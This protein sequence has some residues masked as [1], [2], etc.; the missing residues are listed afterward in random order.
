MKVPR[1]PEQ[2]G[3]AVRAAKNRIFFGPAQDLARRE[4]FHPGLGNDASI[5]SIFNHPRTKDEAEAYLAAYKV[6]E[7]R[8]NQ[9][10]G[11]YQSVD[12]LI[13]G[14][15]ERYGRAVHNA[16]ATVDRYQFLYDDKVNQ[17][18]RIR[19]GEFPDWMTEPT[20]KML[21]E[22]EE[23]GK[24]LSEAKG[25]LEHIEQD[26]AKERDERL[27]YLESLKS[28]EEVKEQESRVSQIL[29]AVKNYKG[30]LTKRLKVPKIRFLRQE[31]GITD[32]TVRERNVA[33]KKL[34]IT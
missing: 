12:Y 5:R 29:N 27:V 24:D 9:L 30:P 28:E 34:N 32:M 4:G 23:A 10:Y 26:A 11:D 13:K 33:V 2:L 31:S 3:L 19:A 7:D 21:T 8:I 22:R 25:K 17:I 6:E 20:P 18:R 14:A 16:Q 1:T 15:K